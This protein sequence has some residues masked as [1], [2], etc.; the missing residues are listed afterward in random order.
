VEAPHQ[1]LALVVAGPWI[2]TG[3][4]D[5]LLS[6]W[7]PLGCAVITTLAGHR[8]AVLSLAVS[9]DA[10]WLVSG[11]GDGTAR[12]WD[13]S[14]ID[15]AIERRHDG[16]VV[17]LV[18]SGDRIVSAGEGAEIV[19][20]QRR[21]SAPAPVTRLV[22]AGEDRFLAVHA[23]G[24]ARVWSVTSGTIE[25]ELRGRFTHVLDAGFTPG[26]MAFVVSAPELRHP[27]MPRRVGAPAQVETF[28]P[29]ASW[30]D[31][32]TVALP[33]PD[34]RL[35]T[36]GTDGSLRVWRAGLLEQTIAAHGLPVVDLALS[37]DGTWLVSVAEDKQG[38]VFR[39]ADG[40]PVATLASE[41]EPFG[42]ATTGELVVTSSDD[43]GYVWAAANGRLL[44]RIPGGSTKLVP[45]GSGVAYGDRQGRVWRRPLGGSVAEAHIGP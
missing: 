10:R 40:L 11:S 13:L 16:P 2:V 6:I 15:V 26:G 17:A 20:A 22:G 33:L 38:R 12:L 34:E 8:D 42:V 7:D 35:V 37:D 36:A 45:I 29:P 28:G 41:E 14:R 30:S 9:G 3:G 25:R 44:G 27:L 5:G 43:G 39:V 19:V 1:P 4:R 18:A 24:V 31:S 32:A 21:L 23:D